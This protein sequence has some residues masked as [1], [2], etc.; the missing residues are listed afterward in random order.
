MS[1]AAYFKLA[2]VRGTLYADCNIQLSMQHLDQ[3]IGILGYGEVGQAIARFYKNPKIQ[4]RTRDDGLTNLDVLHV[5]IPYSPRFV[6]AVRTAMRKARPNITIIH[7][8]VDVGT[9]QKIGGM[10]VHSPIRG[11]HPDLFLGI[12][13][14]VKYIGADDKIAADRA[15]HHLKSIGLRTKVFFP[16]QTTELGKLLDTTYYGLCI[17]FHGE[18]A[19]MCRT[20]NLDFDQV[21]TEFNSS[22]NEGYKKLGMPHVIRPI[23][24]PPNPA[25]GGHCIVPNAKILKHSFHSKALDLILAYQSKKKK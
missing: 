22:Y 5:C 6:S 1:S 15:A 4:N 2:H 16:S 19:R 14:F 18:I 9:T 11:V 3:N 7:S 25:I 24:T 17:A 23:L 10:A 21:A 13:T 12:K 8:T 20:Y